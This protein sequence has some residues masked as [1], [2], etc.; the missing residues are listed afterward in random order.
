M[1][2]KHFNA[3]ND[4]TASQWPNLGR[5]RNADR[6]SREHLTP[7][8]IDRLIAAASKVGRYGHRDATM[9]LMAATTGGSIMAYRHGLRVS[10]L[11]SLRWDQVDLKG[12][13]LHVRR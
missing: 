11:V 1:V 8:E 13:Q 4:F 12:G 9:I 2:K 10:E 3:D 6:R 5:P 7:E